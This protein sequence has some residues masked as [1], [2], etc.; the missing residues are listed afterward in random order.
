MDERSFEEELDALLEELIQSGDT[1]Q[2]VARR[3]G[4]EDPD[5]LGLLAVAA[6]IQDDLSP[7]GPDPQF[8][9]DAELRILNRL[10]PSQAKPDAVR[11]RS[12]RLP[13]FRVPRV[14]S[15]MVAGLLVT[16]I[17]LTGAVGTAAAS[18]NSLPGDGLYAVKRG[19]EQA[20]L[21]LSFSPQGD[22]RLLGEYSDERLEEIEALLNAGRLEDLDQALD[23]F[24]EALDRYESASSELEPELVDSAVD[25]KLLHH[26]EVLQS[27][28]DKVPIQAQTMIESVI[29]RQLEH[30]RQVQERKDARAEEQEQRREDQEASEAE[31]Q[32][33]QN[34]RT[35]EQIARQYEVTPEEVLAVFQGQCAEDWKCVREYYRET[36]GKGGKPDS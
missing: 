7:G 33:E 34:Q 27:V 18:G 8:A 32:D 10:K 25:E 24:A 16:V 14:A 15:A 5:L 4:E 9:H 28:L 29:E 6:E 19:L 13:L 26:I 21:L 1:P 3:V 35:A 11:A 20:R 17:V 2:E 22:L 30:A 36:S 31:R 23:G 12:R